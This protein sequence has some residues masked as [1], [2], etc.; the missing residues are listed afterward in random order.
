MLASLSRRTEAPRAVLF[1]FYNT[2]GTTADP[3]WSS[4]RA[5]LAKHGYTVDADRLATAFGQAWAPFDGA[6][7]IEH[8]AHSGS[9]EDYNGWRL[10]IE[11]AWLAGAGIETCSEELLQAIRAIDDAPTAYRLFDDVPPAIEELRARG[12]RLGLVSNWGWHLHAILEHYGLASAFDVIVSSARCGYRK[13]HPEIYRCALRQLALAPSEVLFV[14]D[15][16]QADLR[17]AS[18][19]GMRAIL[20]DRA[21]SAGGE[22]ITDLGELLRL[23]PE[24]AG[25]QR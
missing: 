25:E 5:V 7:P 19:V 1:D 20:I 24:R 23:L 14:G 2:L 17:G 12:Y 16:P 10:P 21:G 3:A 13:P 18:A 11:R 22:A 15:N 8:S 9:A 6:D 4:V